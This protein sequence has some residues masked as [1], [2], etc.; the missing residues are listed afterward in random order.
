MKKMIVVVMVATMSVTALFATPPAIPAVE[1][2]APRSCTIR[3][4]GEYGGTPIDVNV[5][6]EAE[7]CAE[8][9]GAL[10]KAFTKK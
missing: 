9:A 2:E 6:V 7:N 8:A 10:L 3:I 5:T 1:E 4:R